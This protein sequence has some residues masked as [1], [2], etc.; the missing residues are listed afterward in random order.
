MVISN[1][2]R[3]SLSY[4]ENNKCIKAYEQLI[5]CGVLTYDSTMLND[6]VYCDYCSIYII[7]YGE[8][9][10]FINNKQYSLH[11]KDIAFLG[12]T[13]LI[14][15]VSM[16]ND[17]EIISLFISLDFMSSIFA[18]NNVLLNIWF[19]LKKRLDPYIALD[20]HY[21]ETLQILIINIINDMDS[22]RKNKEFWIINKI[23]CI[24]LEISNIP[25]LNK[26]NNINNYNRT[27][28][29]FQEFFILT[30]KHHK[31]EREISFYANKLNITPAYL[32]KIVKDISSF[33]VKEQIT[34]FLLIDAYHLLLHTDMT[35]QQIAYELNFSDQPSFNKFFKKNTNL[36]P[37][38]YRNKKK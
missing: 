15:I 5:A 33:T 14:K 8:I 12:S 13:D 2:D 38:E 35:V 10:I 21:F 4:F 26:N 24:L 34:R 7:T 9:T 28:F 6:Y 25:T 20:D 29:I 30:S 1:V 37:I 22:E 16:S 19:S 11:R 31:K 18:Y 23:T 36:T 32:S 17:C 27:H 3:V